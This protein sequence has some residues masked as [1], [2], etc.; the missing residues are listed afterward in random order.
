MP[1]V[2]AELAPN[3]DVLVGLETGDDAGVVRLDAEQALVTTADFI[4][5]PFDDPQGYG[6]I[7]AANSISDVYAMG[8]RP[9]CAIN[10]CLFPRGLE[11]EV[12]AEIWRARA[13]CWLGRRGPRRWALGVCAGAVLR[14]LA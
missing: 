3:D 14:P 4:T 2:A 7:A 9:V 13:P 10:L 8:G 12:A 6:R 1:N 5:P 11:K